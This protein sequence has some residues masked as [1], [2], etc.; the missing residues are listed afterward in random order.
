M[1]RHIA[2]TDPRPEQRADTMLGNLYA[3]RNLISKR[4]SENMRFYGRASQIERQKWGT[5]CRFALDCR[6]A[7]PGQLKKAFEQVANVQLR[8]MQNAELRSA[9][10]VL[11]AEVSEDGTVDLIGVVTDPVAM[12]KI[13]ERTY[14]GCLVS[15]DGDVI[16]DVSLIDSPAAFMEKR[17]TVICKIYDRGG[18]VKDP[19]WKL[20]QKMAKTNGIPAIENY[21]ALK[22]VTP[23]T[24]PALSPSAWAAVGNYDAA[25][26]A[27]PGAVD[28]MAAKAAVG[29]AVT[30]CHIEMVKAARSRRVGYGDQQM[31]NFL[32]HGR[33]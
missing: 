9:G 3:D 22:K 29:R 1:S 12:T 24:G 25:V 28:Q 2:S 21:A 33:P 30:Q 16:A 20:A 7:S 17:S 14:T 23:V 27:V 13:S 4:S 19:D 11:D 10:I 15:F 26:A 32:R 8:Q 31:I 18:D 5:K 6:G